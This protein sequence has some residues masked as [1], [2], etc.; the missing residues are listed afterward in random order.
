M[1][2][3]IKDIHNF[4]AG[5]FAGFAMS[6]VGQPFELVKVRMQINEGRAGSLLHVIRNVAKGEGIF[7]F[8][9]GSSGPFLTSGLSTALQ[10]TVFEKG[11][12]NSLPIAISGAFA[13]FANAL[14]VTPLERIRTLQQISTMKKVSFLETFCSLYSS[15]G[16]C[17]LFE[18]GTLVMLREC[19][20]LGFYFTS[21]EL[22]KKSFGPEFHSNSVNPIIAGSVAGLSFWGF[23]YPIDVLKTLMQAK[24][25]KSSMRVGIFDLLIDRVRSR[26]FLSLFQGIAP[27]LL[28]AVPA[29]AAAFF[30]YE[31][32]VHWLSRRF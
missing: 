19:L 12:Q 18:G 6:V 26:G 21:Y 24:P 28:R 9:K 20:G 30:T 10:F 22:C 13:G 3:E 15:N 25:L 7:S 5:S 32:M 27:C 29:N 17:S 8:Y 1:A 11:K 31:W 16:V 14:L 2:N 23:V 4:S